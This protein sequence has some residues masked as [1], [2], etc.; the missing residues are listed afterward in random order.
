MV[1]N[2]NYGDGALLYGTLLYKDDAVTCE[3]GAL[4]HEYGAFLCNGAFYVKVLFYVMV[5]L[6]T[7]YSG[8]IVTLPGCSV[9]YYLLRP[10]PLS[11][12]RGTSR[13]FIISAVVNTR[14]CLSN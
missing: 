2:Y 6:L 5:L 11:V 9:T 12:W 10:W 1:P 4:F 13:G 7:M 14:P 8:C 3:N